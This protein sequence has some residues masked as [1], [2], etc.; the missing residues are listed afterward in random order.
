MVRY[1]QGFS[2]S[3]PGLGQ[4]ALPASAGGAAANPPC[5]HRTAAL[6]EVAAGNPSGKTARIKPRL[7]HSADPHIYV[8]FRVALPVTATKGPLAAFEPA[9]KTDLQGF[10]G[11]C[12]GFTDEPHSEDLHGLKIQSQYETLM[13]TD[14]T[15]RILAHA[16]FALSRSMPPASE[17][18]TAGS[19]GEIL[20]C[21]C[22]CE[23]HHHHQGQQDELLAQRA[24]VGFP[25]HRFEGGQ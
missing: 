22:G 15:F 1:V 13:G 9:D 19:T 7:R 8:P 6:G 3:K 12:G 24:A 20:I 14:G 16:N 23:A 11:E 18:I 4:P 10:C 2:G 25:A 5:P 21:P 17:I